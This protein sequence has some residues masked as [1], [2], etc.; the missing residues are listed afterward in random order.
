MLDN[1]AKTVSKNKNVKIL[2]GVS[3]SPAAAGTG[4]VAGSQLANVIKYSQTFLSFGGV[5]MWDMNQVWAQ[6]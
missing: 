1:W 5:M 4:Y 2:L 6:W 3:G